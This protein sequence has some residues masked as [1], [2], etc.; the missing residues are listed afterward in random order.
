[1]LHLVIVVVGLAYSDGDAKYK[2][3]FSYTYYPGATI[4]LTYTEMTPSIEST[5]EKTGSTE[6]TSSSDTVT[7]DITYTAE[8]DDYKGDVSLILVDTLPYA[9]DESS[10]DLAGGTYNSEE[11]TIT[12]E[13][14]V[15]TVN[16]Y[17]TG[18][19]ATIS[20][21]KTITVLYEDIDLTEESFTNDVEATISLLA[22]TESSSTSS[23]E[24]VQDDED[25]LINV[26]GDLVIKYVD[27]IT[28][29]E[30][31]DSVTTSGKVGESY[32]ISD[33]GKEI[34]GYTLVEEPEEKTGTYTE[35]AQEKI[36]Y[37]IEN[38]SI[39]VT[40]IWDD[41]DDYAENRPD[42]VTIVLYADG[43]EVERIEIA[44]SGEVQDEE[45]DDASLSATDQDE[46][47]IL[48]D[49]NEDD[50]LTEETDTE[51]DEGTTEETDEITATE[52][53]E[54]DSSEID[55]TI[56]DD[57]TEDVTEDETEEEQTTLDEWTYTFEELLKYNTD[58]TEIVYTV[59]E[60]LS[61]EEAENYSS[62]IDGYTITNTYIGDSII[63]QTKEMT[64]EYEEDY[65]IEGETITYSII[66]KNKGEN[67]KDVVIVDTIPEGTTFV[68]GSIKIDE[69]ETY[70]DEDFS[71]RTAEDL[72][73][74]ITIVIDGNS[75]ITLSFEV[76][77]DDDA[78][79]EI[80]NTAT[81]NEVETNEVSILIDDS[82][83]IN[84]YY[85]DKA[86]DTILDSYSYIG[87]TGEEV[88]T[89]SQ[90][91]DGYTLVES[92]DEETYTLT[93]EEIDV[94]YYY[95]YNCE[96]E[97]NYIDYNTGEILD[98]YDLEGLEGETYTTEEKSFTDYTLVETPDNATGEYTK[99]KITVNYYYSN[100]YEYI[101]Y[102]YYDG[103]LDEEAT[104]TGTAT[105]G[106]EIEAEDKSN[107]YD[108][109]EE[110]TVETSMIISSEEE[111]ILNIY[112]KMPESYTIT[113]K[114][115]DYDTGEEIAESEEITGT[116][117]TEYTTEQ[118]EIDGYTYA[119]DTGNTEGTIETEDIEVTYY[120]I[121]E[122]ETTT[123]AKTDNTTTSSDTSSSGTSSTTSSTSTGTTST[124]GVS[125]GDTTPIVVGIV[126]ITILLMNVI[127]AMYIEIKNAKK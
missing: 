102:Y 34:E 107:G 52:A 99:E 21:T 110:S 114:Y 95:L 120:Y 112:Y 51:Q 57:T 6:I 78:K 92:P 45:I 1:M 46:T 83:I 26:T 116:E 96:V 48:T 44:E 72:E 32:D 16:T 37:Y 121:Q 104:E 53:T 79:G 42:S 89:E 73:A 47:D 93:K 18:E 122:V 8:I 20:I 63:I 97:V 59:D 88:E 94:Y 36:Y 75:T 27:L 90:E 30:I 3:S 124:S 69:G 115:V 40:K 22:L 23:T 68:E 38:T 19:A 98:S 87:I 43:E 50:V 31:A 15:D 12:W 49:T 106:E 77:V 85:V 9:I 2:G 126:I 123:E 119:S 17:S 4:S 82:A 24:T 61:E 103:E 33:Y 100:M 55:E 76:T 28:D 101:I 118:K 60:E 86:D 109:D 70:N 64:T 35:E 74:G 117:G 105:V 11:L 39:T 71:E 58:G 62:S 41:N 113:V 14:D 10:S 65:V 81:V 125:T 66:V 108:L 54:E 5:I 56:V 127:M 91:Y 80:T 25:T 111:N 13:E 67:E 84:V 29:E 7:Y